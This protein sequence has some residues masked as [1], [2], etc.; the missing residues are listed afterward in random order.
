[1]S[2]A[3]ELKGL[4]EGVGVADGVGV[5]DGEGVG[6]AVGPLQPAVSTHTAR[7][8]HTA[9]NAICFFMNASANEYSHRTLSDTVATIHKVS[10]SSA[11][12]MRSALD[13]LK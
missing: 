2:F 13:A 9:I 5:T 8:A 3:G 11:C 10:A 4:S 1:M 12:H 6:D 7:T